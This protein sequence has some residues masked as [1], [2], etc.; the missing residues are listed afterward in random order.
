MSHLFLLFFILS[1]LFFGLVLYTI[2]GERP[3]WYASV[4]GGTVFLTMSVFF[5][6]NGEGISLFLPLLS[7]FGLRFQYESFSALYAV[8]TCFLWLVSILS[9]RDYFSGNTAHLNRYYASLFLTLTGCLGVFFATDLWTLFVFFELMSFASYLWVLH[10]EDSAAIK[11]SSLYLA[12]G[13]V[14]GMSILLGLFILSGFTLDLELNH[15]YSQFAETSLWKESRTAC[16]FLFLG[17]GAKAG[18]MFLHDWL[19]PSYTAAPSPST[20]LLTGI[21]SKVG[22]YGIMIVLFRIL[23]YDRDFTVFVLFL[24]SMNMLL[25]AM[26]GFLS[27]DI[28]RTFACSSISQIGFIL[29]GVAFV[30]LLEEHNTLAAYG[31]LFHMVNHSLIKILLF[32]LVGVLYRSAGTTKLEDLRGFGKGKHWFQGLFTVA[33][34]AL[35]GMPLFSG[36]VSKTLLH[37]AIV[38]YMH[39]FETLPLFFL[40]EW[41]FLLSGGFTVA[42]LLKVYSCL[43]WSNPERDWSKEGDCSKTTLMGLSVV[44]MCLLILGLSP[45]LSFAW[46]GEWTADFFH[47]HTEDSIAYFTWTNLRGALISI[48]IGVMLYYF[49]HLFAKN[50][51]TQEYRE[52]ISP[53]DTLYVQVYRPAI[54]GLSLAFAVLMRIADVALETLAVGCSQRYFHSLTIPETF[55]YGEEN[56]VKKK[57]MEV[58]ISHSL[59]YSL[60]MF[61]LGFIF[62]IVYLLVVGGMMSY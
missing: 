25:G 6:L 24:A 13:V 62:T 42:Y 5:L 45:N 14:G 3:L 59:A 61:G 30:N 26:V 1:P 43:F 19:P 36:Y 11:G 39:Y 55:Y 21:L 35:G 34:L 22:I 7:H 58:H 52:Y 12:Y 49:N 40:Y 54:Q 20:G 18:V 31:T 10:K 15:L 46:M 41:L 9:S 8:M 53:E 51:N 28:K 50:T 27:G 44:A 38:E 16:L 48:T 60:L 33:A 57:S 29:W 23:P 56:Q 32:C 37:E 2:E 4:V 17:F 47:I